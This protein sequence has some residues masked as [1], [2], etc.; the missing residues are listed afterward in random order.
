MSTRPFRVTPA[1]P[2]PTRAT[3]RAS[4]VTVAPRGA[5]VTL[6]DGYA[7]TLWACAGIAKGVLVRNALDLQARGYASE[8]TATTEGE[9]S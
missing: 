3:V 8:A 4:L 6:P 1:V 5:R 9:A 7:V 2:V